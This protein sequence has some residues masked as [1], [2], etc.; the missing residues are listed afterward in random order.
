MVK[1]IIVLVTCI[2]PL[3]GLFESTLAAGT[4]ADQHSNYIGSRAPL[5]EKPYIP[6]PLGA[7]KPEGWLQEQLR[8]MRSGMTGHLDELYEKVVG[9]R[10]G[11]LGGDGDGWERGPY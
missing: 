4:Q 2:S 10:N 8:L 11:W 9:P 1:K 5:I 3:F 6:L 7:V